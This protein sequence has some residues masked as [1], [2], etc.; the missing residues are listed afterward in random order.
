M[1]HYKYMS[2]LRLIK[3]SVLPM[4]IV[5]FTGMLFGSV[6]KKTSKLDKE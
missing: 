6:I 1:V 3:I 4:I 2:L 5:F